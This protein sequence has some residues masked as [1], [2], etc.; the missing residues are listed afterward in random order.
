MVSQR[1]A[2]TKGGVLTAF[3]YTADGHPDKKTQ[4]IGLPLLPSGLRPPDS[5]WSAPIEGR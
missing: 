5:M 1:T 4:P 2:R 3:I